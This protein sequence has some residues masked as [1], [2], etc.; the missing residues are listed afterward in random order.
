VTEV[1]FGPSNYVVSFSAT[2]EQH[3]EFQGAPALFGELHVQ[4][5]PPPPALE[6]GASVAQ[7]LFNKVTGA[8][9]VQGT[10]SCNKPADVN[11]GVA[12]TQRISRTEVKRGSSFQ[13]FHCEAPGKAFQL[14]VSESSGGA[15]V[16]GRPAEISMSL[17]AFDPA[18]G[19]WISQTVTQVV[20]LK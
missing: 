5:P 12:L 16:K 18:Y 20:K 17:S 2:F 9:T 13:S 4:N 1:T 10:L 6:L 11:L 14:V 8:A 19:A 15:F 3:C 7:A